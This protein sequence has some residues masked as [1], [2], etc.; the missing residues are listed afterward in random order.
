LAAIRKQFTRE[1]VG[2]H[3]SYIVWGFASETESIFL[4]APIVRPHLT[5][6]QVKSGDERLSDAG[7]PVFWEALRVLFCTG[8]IEFV[9]HIIDADT[10]TGSVIHPCAEWS[11]QPGE[12]AIGDAID[13]PFA[14]A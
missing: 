11:G 13:N 7:V 14:D 1:Q 5:G 6:N 4:D 8:L 12:R 10:D 2:K 3:G 9:E